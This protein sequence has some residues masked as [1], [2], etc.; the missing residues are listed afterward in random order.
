MGQPNRILNRYS[1][2]AR[3]ELLRLRLPWNELEADSSRLQEK[4]AYPSDWDFTIDPFGSLYVTYHIRSQL[5]ARE[6]LRQMHI[7]DGRLRLATIAVRLINE[8][9]RDKDIAGYVA[10][11]GPDLSDPFSGA[12]IRWDPKDRKIYFLDPTDKCVVGS[13]FRVPS[14]KKSG[15]ATTSEINTKAC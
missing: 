14:R 7:I 5:K 3:E 9:V 10:S 12:P 15:M 2:F 11:A 8:N 6:M 1:A 4:Y 13:Y